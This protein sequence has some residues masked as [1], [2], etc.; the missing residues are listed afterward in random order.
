MKSNTSDLVYP[1]SRRPAAVPAPYL[2][3]EKNDP[4][5]HEAIP[6]SK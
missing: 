6:D 3:L 1:A 2:R 5:S 4:A